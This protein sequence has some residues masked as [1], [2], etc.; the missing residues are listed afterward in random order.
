MNELIP[1]V[2][3]VLKLVDYIGYIIQPYL[4][5][6]A[7]DIPYIVVRDRITNLSISTYDALPPG[8]LELFHISQS[9]EP[10]SLIAKHTK[11]KIAI[12]ELF[13]D[14]NLVENIIKP[15][16]DKQ[17]TESI[18]LI[19]SHNIKLFHAASLPHLYPAEQIIVKLNKATTTLIFNRTEEH[20]VYT[21]ETYTD[22]KKVDL[23]DENTAILTN[24]PCYIIN[25]NNLLGFNINITGKLI[26]PFLSRS[27]ITIP[28][29]IEHKYFKGFIKKIINS[30]DVKASGFIIEDINIDPMPYLS[31]EFDWTGTNC[32]ILEFHYGDRIVFPNNLN[33]SFTDLKSDELNITFYRYKRRRK[34]EENCINILKS[35]GLLQTENCFRLDSDQACN[36]IDWFLF[37]KSSLLESGFQISREFSDNYVIESPTLSYQLNNN[38]DWFDLKITVIIGENQIPFRYL[39]KNILNRER[40]YVLPD[41]RKFFIPVEW[42][43]RFHDLMVH[44]RDKNDSLL[45][46]R[47]HFKLLQNVKEFIPE[48]NNNSNLDPTQVD[49]SDDNLPVLSNV[50]L[51]SYQTTGYMWL[52]KLMH[53]GFGG[54]LADDMGL[55]KTIQMIAYLAAYYPHHSKV[56]LNTNV[57]DSFVAP[58]AASQLQLF[59]NTPHDKA[60]SLLVLPASL[61]HNWISELKKLAPWITFL[62]YTGS[63]RKRNKN[64]LSRYN[65]IIT[66]YGTLRND[67]EFLSDYHFANIILDESQ[68]I[69]NPSSKTSNAIFDLMGQHK[70]A[71]TGTPLE[72]NLTDIWSQMNFLNPGLLG[73]QTLFISYYANPLFKNPEAPEGLKLLSIIQPF[74]LRRT[75][76]AVAPE[77]PELFETI[78][79]CTMS[80]EQS[81]FYEKEKSKIRNQVLEQLEKGSA[82]ETPIMV[83]KALMQLR[84]IANHPKLVGEKNI[85][86]GKF[87]EIT[88]KL[89]TI[90]AGKH[91]VLVFSSFVKH[92]NIIAEYCTEKEY[93]YT[94]LTGATV[95]RAKVV[96]EFKSRKETQIFLISLKAGGVGL[97]LFEADYVFILDPWWNPAAEQ[98]AINRA[99]RIGQ[100][101]TVFVYRFITKNTMEEKI[102]HLQKHKKTLADAFIQPHSVI[103][104]LHKEEIS[105]LFT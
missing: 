86:S 32:L 101:S 15:Y 66:T 3:A 75:K 36:L 92:L 41:G 30:S 16:I 76:E 23:Q 80:A 22:G 53:S 50:Q 83:L 17:L 28:K 7:D 24:K 45:L 8:A 82:S 91:K 51:R 25:R 56:S 100:K 79:F 90:I 65:L 97:N 40:M 95:N 35:K 98:Q 74:I 77:L 73:S 27:V 1:S 20:T 93:P 44:T 47:Y 72:N 85:P 43:E 59:D 68:Y 39:R 11:K 104:G 88:D 9:L 14:A 13:S 71:L 60:S 48:L 26:T 81:V 21:L 49:I 78:S 54:I 89:D 61:I 87:E 4:Y 6:P 33:E 84:Q 29:H 18:K 96:D 5:Y 34:F 52:R 57:T 94:I 46:G 55:G 10:A 12:K 58:T 64:T 37:H 38:Y 67:V 69:K 70:F 103:A 105:K 99:H 31:F 19:T 2:V 42:F 62:V 102:L 63:T